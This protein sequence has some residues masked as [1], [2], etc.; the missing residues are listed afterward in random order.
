MK[1]LSKLLSIFLMFALLV[2]SFAFL[3]SANGDPF[4]ATATIEDAGNANDAVSPQE[5][6]FVHSS[7]GLANWNDGNAIKTYKVTPT[8]SD[9]PYVMLKAVANKTTANHFVNV[10]VDDRPVMD[11]DTDFYV[12]EL[13]IATE[14]TI[15]GGF[16]INPIITFA[17]STGYA[18]RPDGQMFDYFKNYPQLSDGNWHHYVMVGDL[19][20]NVGYIYIDGVKVNTTKE[21]SA[22]NADNKAKNPDN[23]EY[24]MESFR[25]DIEPSL[26][27]TIGATLC[28]DNVSAKVVDSWEDANASAA[29]AAEKLPAIAK[30]NGTETSSAAAVKAALNGAT[31]AEV[32]F[33]R[34]FSEQITVTCDAVVETNGLTLANLVAGANVELTKDGTVWTYDAPFQ[35]SSEYVETADQATLLSAVKS[36]LPGNIL[37]A[38]KTVGCNGLDDANNAQGVPLQG[39]TLGVTTNRFT[40][41]KYVS[42]AGSPAEGANTYITFMLTQDG[43]VEVKKGDEN[44]YYVLDMDLAAFETL[45]DLGLYAVCRSTTTGGCFGANIKDGGAFLGAINS[46]PI[47]EFQ[48][49]TVILDFDADVAHT[50]VNGALVAS[51]A[52]GVYGGK[53]DQ[54]VAGF[55]FEQFRGFS[56]CSNDFAFGNVLLRKATDADDTAAA[57]TAGNLRDWGDNVFDESYVLPTLPPVASVNGVNVLSETAFD[58]VLQLKADTPVE[59]ELF[60]NMNA[61]VVVNANAVIKTNGLTANFVAGAG[62]TSSTAGEGEATVITFTAPWKPSSV[63]EQLTVTGNQSDKTADFI[64]DTTVEGNLMSGRPGS[65]IVLNSV[66]NGFDPIFNA[67]KVTDAYT[68]ESFLKLSI[69]KDMKTPKNDYLTFELIPSSTTA[70]EV[71]DIPTDTG[72]YVI[73]IDIATDSE[74][75]NELGIQNI[76]R[77]STNEGSTFPFGTPIRPEVDTGAL[78]KGEWSHLTLVGDYASNNQYVFINGTL[79]GVVGNANFNLATHDYPVVTIKGIRVNLGEQ[80]EVKEGQSILLKGYA[81]RGFKDDVA[82]GNLDEAIAAGDLSVWTKNV[83]GA[84]G[85]LLPAVA[86][87]DGVKYGSAAAVT[88]ALADGGEHTVVLE[89]SF[90]G[91]IVVDSTATFVTNGI[92]ADIVPAATKVVTLSDGSL[93]VQGIIVTD[94]GDGTI[95]FVQAN[96]SNLA[97]T[98][99]GITFVSEDMENYETIY[100]TFGTTIEYVGDVIDVVARIEAGKLVATNWLWTLD[101]ESFE[102]DLTGAVAAPEHEGYYAIAENNIVANAGIKYNLSLYSNFVVNFFV[103]KDTATT[104]SDKV[105]TLDGV[106]YY[107]FEVAVDACDVADDVVFAASLTVGGTVYEGEVSVNIVKYAEKIFANAAYSDGLKKTVYAALEYANEAAKLLTTEGVDVPEIAVALTAGAAY[108][109]DDA[110]VDAA[111]DYTP[112]LPFISAGYLNLDAQP[113]FVIVLNGAYVGEV[114]MSYVDVDGQVVAQSYNATGDID[115]VITL[116]TMRVYEF[117]SVI[118]VTFGETVGYYSLATY[119]LG[120][121]AQGT[122][123]EFAVA[124]NNYAKLAKAYEDSFL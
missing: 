6:N 43:G 26:D 15:I 11:F 32:E 57:I 30:V 74:Y 24:Y 18:T 63:T 91:Q 23:T 82:A 39:M 71:Y 75:I 124:L 64:V 98:A 42:V 35:S 21:G 56:S 89:D 47:G 1:K 38:I 34:E 12:I 80:I 25:I 104:P 48:H 66:N 3:A 122:P 117:N 88:E 61:A 92:D 108:A 17:G 83:V 118:T 116:D 120:L 20:N 10:T 77:K 31:V 78:V 72:Y 123:S 2:T 60:Q 103:P 90:A 53:A 41:D 85:E 44:V 76:A 40:S 4:E 87:V 79:V 7:A 28:I 68:G 101:L 55:K 113:D 84:A 94:N 86:T 96:E 5:G 13:D 93:L 58:K 107:V 36:A 99:A 106:D 97:E 29:T 114:V 51:T 110:A 73:D 109:T 105:A 9:N 121:E 111:Q 95:D 62:V 22:Y 16:K 54:Y 27:M 59:I 19:A 52:N 65:C 33:L 14:G 49:V 100:Y 70:T 69:T 112:L 81:H 8:G 115:Q 67:Y 102:D 50:F 119:I 37:Y 46:Q 45:T